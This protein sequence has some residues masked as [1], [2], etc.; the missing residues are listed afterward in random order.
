MIII[1]LLISIVFVL[2]TLNSADRQAFRPIHDMF[3]NPGDTNVNMQGMFDKHRQNFIVQLIVII[4]LVCIIGCLFLSAFLAHVLKPLH[5]FE[6]KVSNYDE[7][8]LN[9]ELNINA[10]CLEING[11]QNAFNSLLKRINR[12]FENQKL[13]SNNLA[14]EFKT[15]L[16]II[17]TNKQVFDLEKKHTIKEYQELLNLMDNQ[18]NRLI[19]LVETLIRLNDNSNIIKSEFS[20]KKLVTEIKNELDLLLKENKLKLKIIND[21]VINNDYHLLKIALTNLIDNAIKY[22]GD[23]NKI[24]VL[25]EDDKISIIDYGIGIDS[26]ELDNIFN[27]FYRVDN[28]RSRQSGGSGLGLTFTKQIIELLGYHISVDNREDGSTFIINLI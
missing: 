17:K 13:F 21:K 8:V 23:S 10:N 19:E 7:K 18:N 4:A 11:I 27:P 2:L 6:K 5:D 26:E 3:F 15:P 24:E 22:H 16:S 12:V 14:H 28:S 1:V 9:E 25:I 20:I